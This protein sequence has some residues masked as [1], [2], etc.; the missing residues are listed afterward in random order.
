MPDEVASTNASGVLT[1]NII[2]IVVD[3][4]E[5]GTGGAGVNGRTEE[6]AV[7]N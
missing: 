1:T 4:A 6:E 5:Y 3:E 2:H 7:W